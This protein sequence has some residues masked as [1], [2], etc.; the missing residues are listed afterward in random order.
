MGDEKEERVENNQGFWIQ[1][2]KGLTESLTKIGISFAN[3][4]NKTKI[5]QLAGASSFSLKIKILFRCLLLFTHLYHLPFT[6]W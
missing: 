6:S 4:P 1:V 5:C 3:W 2:M